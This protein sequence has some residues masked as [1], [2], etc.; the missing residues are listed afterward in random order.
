MTR[1]TNTTNNAMTA[2]AE[3]NITF[4]CHCGKAACAKK[5]GICYEKNNIHS[6]YEKLRP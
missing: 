4:N 6:V 3:K 5:C 2:A 1:T